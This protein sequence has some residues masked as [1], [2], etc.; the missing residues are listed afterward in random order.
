MINSPLV[1]NCVKAGVLYPGSGTPDKSMDPTKRAH[2]HRKLETKLE[3]MGQA[4]KSKKKDH[5]D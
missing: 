4:R 2:V 1:L 5:K 3:E